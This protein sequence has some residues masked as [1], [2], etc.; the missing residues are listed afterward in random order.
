MSSVS[1]TS[2]TPLTC[3]VDNSISIST[4]IPASPSLRGN[5]DTDSCALQYIPAVT[6]PAIVSPRS[7]SNGTNGKSIMSTT[8]SPSHLQVKY[9]THRHVDPCHA[10]H[11]IQL[12]AQQT[13]YYSTVPCTSQ[14]YI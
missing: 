9:Y 1:S 7:M 12:Q 4:I 2:T 11:M 10:D 5:H 6:L 8:S 3:T 14:P 13:P